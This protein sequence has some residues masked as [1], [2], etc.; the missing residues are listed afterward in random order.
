MFFMSQRIDYVAKI[1][2]FPVKKSIFA[3]KYCQTFATMVS[4]FFRFFSCPC[5]LLAAFFLFSPFHHEASAQTYDGYATYYGKKAHGRKTADGSRHD[6]YGY[7]CAH[8]TLPFGTQLRVTHVRS[9]KSVVV[10][11]TDRGPFG[12]KDRIVDLSWAAA[13]DLGMLSEG[14]AKVKVEVVKDDDKAKKDDK[15]GRK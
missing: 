4:H 12:Y 8:R 7:V 5:F 11:V 14:V 3:E 15:E 2:I 10:K 6:A 13:R 9:G 1:V